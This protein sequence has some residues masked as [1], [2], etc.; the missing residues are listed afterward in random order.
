MAGVNLNN[1]QKFWPHFR[2]HLVGVV[3]EK[4]LVERLF[5]EPAATAKDVVVDFLAGE[6]YPRVPTCVA[7][8]SE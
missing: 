5:V 4:H 8:A 3:L 7:T 2:I 1:R 6:V